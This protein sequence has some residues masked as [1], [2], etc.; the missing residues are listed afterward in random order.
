MPLLW[1]L[2]AG[3]YDQ[4]NREYAANTTVFP[5]VPG[6]WGEIEVAAYGIDLGT[7]Y[8][9]VAT[10]D[11]TGRAVV[12]KSAIGEDTT[13]SVVY[14]ESSDSVVVG[15]A[16]KKTALLAPELV[17]SR[18]MRLMG[19]GD[20]HWEYHGVRHTPVSVSALILRE[21]TRAAA[22]QCGKQVRDVVITVPAYFGIAER[23]AT[24][25]AG[26]LAGLEVLD[27]LAEPVAAALHYQALNDTGTTRHLLVYDLGDTFDATV[28]RLSGDDVEVVCMDGDHQLGGPDWDAKIVEFMLG[29]FA[30]RQPD[31]DPSADEQFM[32]DLLISAESLKKELSETQFPQSH[33]AFRRHGRAGRAHPDPPGGTHRGAARAHHGD[34]Q[35]DHRHR[36]GNGR[37]RTRR[38]SAGRRHDP[39]AGHRG[40]PQ[41]AVRARNQAA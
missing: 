10:V 33:L 14:F 15:L 40:H 8:S 18:V 31:I 21:L 19:D 24:R 20:V 29:A 41:G 4:E 5:A 1:V 34:N 32:Q 36:T 30:A 16:A 6:R 2:A 12:L 28:I 13:P 39:D 37:G 27:I 35:Q 26:Q 22:E 9:C 38:R 23:E 7:S 25:R 3:F 11:D 17:A